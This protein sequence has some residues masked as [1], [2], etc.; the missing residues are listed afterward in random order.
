MKCLFWE[1]IFVRTCKLHSCQVTL[2]SSD[3][4]DLL[5]KIQLL[6]ELTEESN[7]DIQ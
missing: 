3:T 1:K 2:S 7:T 6:I 4:S 5:K